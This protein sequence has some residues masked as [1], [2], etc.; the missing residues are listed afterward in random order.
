MV[1]RLVTMPLFA[2]ISDRVGHKK[3]F[4]IS[5]LGMIAMTY[6]WLLLFLSGNV[7]LGIVG[8]I[9]IYVP[10]GVNF[11][12]LAA[13]FAKSM[14]ATIAQSGISLGYQIG[15]AIGGGLTPVAVAALVSATGTLHAAAWFIIACCLVSLLCCIAIPDISKSP[16]SQAETTA[17]GELSN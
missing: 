6:P 2:R 4:I 11:G 15:T 5:L 17:V 7:P 8:Y 13:L 14:P 16:S 3:I 10:E 12:V 9:A 1:A